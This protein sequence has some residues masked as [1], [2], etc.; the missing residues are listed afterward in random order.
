MGLEQLLDYA[1]V[2]FLGKLDGRAERHGEAV[3]PALI[4]YLQGW[5]RPDGHRLAPSPDELWEECE[6]WLFSEHPRNADHEQ[7]GE[8]RSWLAAGV[9]WVGPA[10]AAAPPLRARA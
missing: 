9:G 1:L 4:P 3:W 7:W 8:M 6:A 5:W 2:W 10:W